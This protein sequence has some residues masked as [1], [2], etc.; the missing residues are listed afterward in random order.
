[1]R[2]IILLLV[3][4]FSICLKAQ[5]EFR[6]YQKESKKSWYYI[7]APINGTKLN[8]I[9]ITTG[10]AGFY[11]KEHDFNELFPDHSFAKS[12]LKVRSIECFRKK[13]LVKNIF[14]GKFNVGNVCFVGN[15]F[16]L[17][18]S[19]PFTAKLDVQNLCNFSDSTKNVINLNFAEQKLAFVD[20]NAVDTTKLSKFDIFSVYP[21]IVI[22]VPITIRQDG[23]M[24]NLEGNMRLY[25]SNAE[26]IEFY[27]SKY[28]DEFCKQTKVK[29]IDVYN[30]YLDSYK[31]IRYDKL[32]IGTKYFPNHFIPIMKNISIKNSF[33]SING[34]FF[35]GNFY[36]DLKKNK[37][38]YE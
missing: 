36:I 22:K 35:K 5:T 19:Y 7:S 38:Y 27:P 14:V 17:E 1:M 31:A 29:L 16:V 21:S 4:L 25:L 13:Y 26:L 37:L 12:K 2:S 30:D 24:W 11:I 28:L 8:D 18:N 15:I 33:G 20:M 9:L 10:D 23:K 6:V 34:S 32:K 3:C